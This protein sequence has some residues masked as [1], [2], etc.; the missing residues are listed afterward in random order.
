ML[1][2]TLVIKCMGRAHQNLLGTLCL[3][4]KLA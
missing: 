3:G 1:I 4:R 2:L